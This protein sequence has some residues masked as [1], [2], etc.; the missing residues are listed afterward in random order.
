MDLQSSRFRHFLRNLGLSHNGFIFEESRQQ[1]LCVHFWVLPPQSES[2]PACLERD[3]C[4]W[5]NFVSPVYQ[6]TEFELLHQRCDRSFC[7]GVSVQWL[8]H[9][10][11]FKL[12]QQF[13]RIKRI[14]SY[15]VAS[16]RNAV[17][18]LFPNHLLRNK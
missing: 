12:F 11:E 14:H 8:S 2:N 7:S 5:I 4:S 16:S 10:G 6:P 9:C 18:S 17:L 13:K 15:M 1:V 3:G